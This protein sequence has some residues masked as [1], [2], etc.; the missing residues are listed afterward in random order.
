MKS[1]KAFW[2]KEQKCPELSPQCFQ[3]TSR[4]QNP[5]SFN[6]RLPTRKRVMA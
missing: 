5:C 3:A 2:V 6:H 1:T 4:P